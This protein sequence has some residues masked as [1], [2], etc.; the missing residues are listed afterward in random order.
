MAVEMVVIHLQLTVAGESVTGWARDDYGAEHR[1]DG[2]LGL[3][4]AI[5]ALIAP[6]S[7]G[8]GSTEGT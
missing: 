3:L 5:D 7:G 8:A 4:A 1:F 2:R 6:P